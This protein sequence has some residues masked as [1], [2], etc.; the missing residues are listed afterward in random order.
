MKN[1]YGY[2]HLPFV[3]FL[4]LWGAAMFN[5]TLYGQQGEFSRLAKEYVYDLGVRDGRLNGPGA[6]LLLYE[7]TQADFVCIG[8]DEGVA[9]ISDLIYALYNHSQSMGLQYAHIALGVSDYSARLLES[10]ALDVDAQSLLPQ[11]LR[12]HPREIPAMEYQEEVDLLIKLIEQSDNSEEILWGL[13][14]VSIMAASS[15]LKEL[16]TLAPDNKTAKLVQ[17]YAKKAKKGEE[18][19]RANRDSSATFLYQSS[20]QDFETLKAPFAEIP[21]ATGIATLERSSQWYQQPYAEK[22][23]LL[24]EGMFNRFT[25]NYLRAQSLEAED[26]RAFIKLKGEHLYRGT[27]PGTQIPAFGKRL[28]RFT[29]A[30]KQ[31]MLNIRIMAAPGAKVSQLNEQFASVQVPNTSSNTTWMKHLTDIALDGTLS[32]YH[33]K[34]LQRQLWEERIPNPLTKLVLEYDILIL[35]GTSSPSSPL[36]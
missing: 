30:K 15:I 17:R 32:V 16:S 8:E 24:E 12:S 34:A 19:F 3:L 23:A 5:A 7:M 9:E 21:E 25:R 11:Y 1:L 33:L 28:E 14:P 13:G 6:E 20:T 31:R 35:L 4:A 26:P 29:E 18:T 10:L 27:V 2:K 22:R 36:N